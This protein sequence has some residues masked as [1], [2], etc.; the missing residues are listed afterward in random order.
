MLIEEEIGVVFELLFGK[1]SAVLH[2][3][4]FLVSSS[5]EENSVVMCERYVVANTLESVHSICCDLC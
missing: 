2:K 1:S 4:R 3:K 5:Q